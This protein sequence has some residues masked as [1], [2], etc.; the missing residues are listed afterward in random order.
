MKEN[1]Q[2]II[3]NSY[4]PISKFAVAC[5]LVCKDNQEFIG[6]NVENPSLKSGMCAEQVAI[7]SAIAG[8]YTKGDFKEIHVMG[9]GKDY[10][11]PCFLCR[12]LLVE[13]FDANAKVI[14]Y[15]ISGKA[16]EYSIMDLCPNA[17]SLKD[18]AQ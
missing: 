12:E 5:I 17:F 4:C 15:N 3:K 16:K 7:S 13:L 8:G 1:L 11:M 14:C 9:S 6:V 18:G 10:C 2:K